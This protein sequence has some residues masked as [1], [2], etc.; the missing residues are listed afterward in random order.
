MKISSREIW[1]KA[2]FM[3]F[4]SKR[5]WVCL[6]LSLVFLSRFCFLSV[7]FVSAAIQSRL[8]EILR[9]LSDLPVVIE[10]SLEVSGHRNNCEI[11]Y[12]NPHIYSYCD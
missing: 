4:C 12:E 3:D 6:V 1:T 5:T 10:V 7:L 9:I 11:L 2:S 8:S